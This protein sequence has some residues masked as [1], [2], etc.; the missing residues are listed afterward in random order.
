MKYKKI[1]VSVLLATFNGEKFI[2]TQLDS[3]IEQEES[4]D[5]IVICDDR[6]TDRTMEIICDYQ[7]RYPNLIKIYQN[8]IN[9][10]YAMNFWDSIKFTTGDIVIFSDQDDIWVKSKVSEIKKVFARNKYV[11]AL[12]T[13]Y[14][15]IDSS[16]KIIHSYK[17]AHYFNDN[18][19]RKITLKQFI[20][21]PKFPGMSMAIRKD[22]YTNDFTFKEEYLLA[23]DWYL[24]Q[25]AAYQNGLYFLNKALAL[26]R[27][28]N[29]NLVGVSSTIDGKFAL[30]KRLSVIKR[31]EAMTDVL[32]QIYLYDKR[33]FSYI[34][35]V[36]INVIKR[37]LY[38]LNKNILGVCMNFFINWR[39]YSV[40]N[41]AGDVYAILKAYKFGD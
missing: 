32:M 22:L 35:K 11:M 6:S 39:F 20:K 9:K 37:Y 27:Q 23:H 10:G 4:V 13:A 21:A 18:R 38:V 1:K 5:E 36:K 24:N 8:E 28:H 41:F 12:N 7:K 33:M 25:Q 30:E 15:L 34:T 14:K 29:N 40:R 16:G 2:Q 17:D 26:Y 19:L 31:E 3:I